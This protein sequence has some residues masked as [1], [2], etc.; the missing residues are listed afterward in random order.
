MTLKD[1][2]LSLGKDPDNLAR[3][4]EQPEAAM[5]E[6]DLTPADKK[7]LLSRDPYEIHRAITAHSGGPPSGPITFICTFIYMPAIGKPRPGK[8]PVGG[9]G[10][11][12]RR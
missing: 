4:I 6:A 8:R 9:K 11:P 5:K 2:L 10:R 3:Y 7:V 1:F 12:R